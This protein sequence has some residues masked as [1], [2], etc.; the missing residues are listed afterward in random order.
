MS[1]FYQN[2][3]RIVKRLAPIGRHAIMQSGNFGI[4]KKLLLTTPLLAILL[5]ISGCAPKT[6]TENTTPKPMKLSIM[7]PSDIEAYK[8][9]MAEHVQVGGP[10]P[11]QTMNFEP[12]MVEVAED[13]DPVM[14]LAQAAAQQIPT[15][16]GPPKATVAYLGVRGKIAYVL[17]DIDLDGWTGSSVSTATIH[18][19]IE[20]TLLELPEIDQVVF[21]YAP[22]DQ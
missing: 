18:P 14:A 16:G 9:A 17:L 5:L 22:G 3:R 12:K 21:A 7:V 1:K 10:D 6:A 15:G 20:K 11:S 8:Q 4:V 2:S 19:I 13:E